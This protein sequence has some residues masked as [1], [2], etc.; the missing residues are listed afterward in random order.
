MLEVPAS[1]AILPRVIYTSIFSGYEAV[2]CSKGK[3]PLGVLLIALPFGGK[4][5]FDGV[6]ACG[7]N[8]CASV[9]RCVF[10]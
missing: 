9:H 10:G 8:G 4:I 2:L 7:A 5:G 6:A 1:N 3:Q